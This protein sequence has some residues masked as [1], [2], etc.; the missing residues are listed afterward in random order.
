MTF[1]RGPTHFQT[2]LT[3]Q[4]SSDRYPTQRKSDNSGLQLLPSVSF[5]DAGK[6]TTSFSVASGFHTHDSPNRL[7]FLLINWAY[8]MKRCAPG[9]NWESGART[10]LRAGHGPRSG[11]SP[12]RALLVKGGAGPRVLQSR[13]AVWNLHSGLSLSASVPEGRSS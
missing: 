1:L 9:A 2:L 10:E 3:T 7:S 6:R 12:L 11:V 4:R 13:P 5:C 8:F